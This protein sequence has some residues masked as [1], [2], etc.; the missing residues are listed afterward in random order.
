MTCPYCLDNRKIMLPARSERLGVYPY[1][2]GGMPSES[3]NY[4]QFDCPECTPMVPYTRVRAM[5]VVTSY[6][7]EEYAKMQVPIERGLAARFGEY[8]MREGLI[9]FSATGSEDFGPAANKIR[10][11]ATLGVVS[12]EDVKR[13]GAVE[14]EANASVKLDPSRY[15]KKPFGTK[16]IPWKPKPLE[17]M[18][19]EVTDEFD[20][21]RDAIGGRFAGLD[22]G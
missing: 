14:E 10:V 8:L 20:E 19:D 7:P 17:G 16:R 15:G 3:L 2:G 21:P 1:D 6:S 18:N 4:K 12:R 22:F 11:S 5:K 9:K 13:V